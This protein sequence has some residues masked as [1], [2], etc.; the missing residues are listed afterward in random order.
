MKIDLAADLNMQDHTGYCWSLL[1]DASDP[2]IID[3]GAVIPAGGS[4]AD[5]EVVAVCCVVE[6]ESVND[7]TV[8]RFEILPG[9]IE[10]CAVL[11]KRHQVTV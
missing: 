9:H 3:P 8:V 1:E 11:V 10:D 4:D 7:H 5:G 6:L 2:D